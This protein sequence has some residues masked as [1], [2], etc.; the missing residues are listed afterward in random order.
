VTEPN[1]NGHGDH[2]EMMA[3]TVDIDPTKTSYTASLAMTGTYDTFYLV[4]Y[5]TANGRTFASTASRVKVP[6]ELLPGAPGPVAVAGVHDVKLQWEVNV[7]ATTADGIGA[8]AD[9]HV[10]QGTKSGQEAT[11]PVAASLV[12]TEITPAWS[13]AAQ[14]GT[15]VRMDVTVK[16]LTA[17]TTYYF[18]VAQGD[19][20]GFGPASQEVSA[21][22]TG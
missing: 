2:I 17:G 7:G 14:L 15:D 16:G 5:N 9:F 12:T 1:S 11:T 8:I 6:L 20:A 10:F 22:A 19:A 13:A 21:T 4:A 18:T 3:K